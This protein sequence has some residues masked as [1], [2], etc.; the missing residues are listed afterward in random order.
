MRRYSRPQRY[1]PFDR[2][3]WQFRNIRLGD[4]YYGGD[5]GDATP[6]PDMY[7]PV[8]LP[9][10]N[11]VYDYAGDAAVNYA[12]PY[13]YDPAVYDM[14]PYVLGYLDGRASNP[15]YDTNPVEFAYTPADIAPRSAIMRPDRSSPH[16]QTVP[17]GARMPLHFVV[18]MPSTIE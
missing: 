9:P 8:P 16:L 17:V 10:F 12:N 6:P 4:S 1:I 15:Y 3:N 18:T 14:D 11:E 7:P 2:F 5:F 13:A